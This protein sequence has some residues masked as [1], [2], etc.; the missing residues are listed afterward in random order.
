MR[1]VIVG[2]GILA[3]TTAY[4]LLDRL[5]AND[6][7][8]II[9]PKSRGCSA[10]LAAAAMLNSFAEVE[11]DSLEHPVDRYRFTLSRE[12]GRM[13]PEFER[14][15]SAAAGS[16]AGVADAAERACLR[17]GPECG[18]YLI[19]NTAADSLD[20]ENFDAIV[21]AL[22]EYDE[23]FERVEPRSIPNYAPMQR[24]RATR[25]L[26]IPGEGWI[27][28]RR[29]IDALDAVLQG[30]SR[31]QG[32]DIEAESLVVSSGRVSEVL[33]ADGSRVEGDVFLLATGATVSGVL[34][35]SGL[36]IPV[37]R[38]FYGVGTSIEIKSPD[39][40]HTHC[41]RTPNRGL[42]CGVY[43]APYYTGPDSNNDHIL[44]G[45][46]NF[47][48]PTPYFHGRLTSIGTLMQAA[49]EQLNAT[50]YRADF[51]R[52]NVGW[53]PTSQDT[54]PLLGATSISNL[55][56][57]SGTKRDGFHLSPLLSHK[58]ADGLL[59]S[60]DDAEF[61]VFAPERKP[62][63]TLTREQAVDKAVRHQVSA[64]YQHGFSPAHNRMPDQVRRMFRED[65]ERLHDQC[66]ATD[67]G[68]PPEMLDMYR[69]GHATA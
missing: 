56:I 31:V 21:A 52:A 30:D 40:R 51:V 61:A 34:Q 13:W 28:P 38:V 27:N 48:S 17:S 63:R 59:G 25:A 44:I 10:T 45:A 20:D 66:G 43:S 46:S 47:M 41:V 6:D 36:D 39:A 23:P 2:N 64:S 7:I 42:A 1:I 4:R 37:Q 68:I 58:L 55:H 11:T 54:Y 14:E 49:V 33:L 53:R 60:I 65:V 18:T 29:V 32:R 26:L 3:L 57:A 69:Y 67:W 19:N 12:A 22:T 24:Y 5:Q 15:L 9:G 50:F 62:L 16:V 35:R 8:V